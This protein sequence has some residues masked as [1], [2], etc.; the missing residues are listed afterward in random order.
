MHTTFLLKINVIFFLSF[1]GSH[2]CD[3]CHSNNCR[4]NWALFV[5]NDFTHDTK[6][7]A[8]ALIHGIIWS[9]PGYCKSKK[10]GLISVK[11]NEAWAMWDKLDSI[12]FILENC[13]LGTYCE[14]ALGCIKQNRMH[15]S[16]ENHGIHLMQWLVTELQYTWSGLQNIFGINPNWV[17][18]TQDV[19][20][21][22][23]MQRFKDLQALISNSS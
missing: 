22:H 6:I 19:V 21:S 18:T 20:E 1:N 4:I 11:P 14:I 3:K 5:K 7:I 17:L 15:Y 8:L 12:V 23:F 2:R 10:C 9:G 13:I 16:L